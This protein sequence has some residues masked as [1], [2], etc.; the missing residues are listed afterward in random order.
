MIDRTED[1]EIGHR[2]LN[3]ARRAIT[4]AAGDDPDRL[5]YLRRFVFTRLQLDE[6]GAKTGI[7][8]RL[9]ERDPRCHR[10]K[11]KFETQ[12]HVDLHR[13]NG[14]RGYT[15]ENCVLMHPEC[16]QKHHRE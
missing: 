5:F 14:D 16:H 15:D 11:E 12:T 9:Y 1:R 4:R 3:N 6:R 10:C 2:I 8:G 7:K 13:I